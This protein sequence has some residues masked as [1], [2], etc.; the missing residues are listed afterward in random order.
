MNVRLN[1]IA[2]ISSFEGSRGWNFIAFNT[3]SILSGEVKLVETVEWELFVLIFMARSSKHVG[4]Q[5]VSCSK[6]I[7]SFIRSI[8]VI[9]IEGS[10]LI[11]HPELEVLFKVPCWIHTCISHNM[12]S[13]NLIIWRNLVLFAV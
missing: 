5:N 1:N 10:V 2:M 8:H 3:V 9:N 6:K 7:R 13:D 4:Y 12:G 11:Q